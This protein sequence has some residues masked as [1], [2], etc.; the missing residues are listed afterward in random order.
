MHAEIAYQT[1]SQTLRS[2]TRWALE[3]VSSPHFLHSLRDESSTRG[4]MESFGD[5]D[6]N[7]YAA[8]GKGCGSEYRFEFV[9]SSDLVVG[10][11]GRA[12]SHQC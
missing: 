8:R 12:G 5:T 10:H 6:Y 9:K 4:L 2:D 3:E 1:F 11:R 7:V